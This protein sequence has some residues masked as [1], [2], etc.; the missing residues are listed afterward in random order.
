MG[1]EVWGAV[2]WKLFHQLNSQQSLPTIAL[3]QLEASHAQS[4]ALDTD[5]VDTLDSDGGS[6]HQQDLFCVGHISEL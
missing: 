4:L 2:E 3:L 6:K 1:G 5:A